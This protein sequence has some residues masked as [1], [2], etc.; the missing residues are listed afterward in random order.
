MYT[1]YENEITCPHCGYKQ[2]DSE[3]WMPGDL[4]AE[5]D[6]ECSSCG[7]PFHCIRETEVTYSTFTI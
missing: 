3:E 6:E 2:K 7:E 1:K 5:A 4:Y